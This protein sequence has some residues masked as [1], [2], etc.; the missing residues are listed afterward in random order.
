M[1]EL[2]AGHKESHWM[3]FIFPQ[4]KSLGHSEM[5]DR[6]AMSGAAEARAYLAHD[7]LGLRLDECV[8]A[9]LD[10][11]EIS[12]LQILGSPDDL[13]LRSCLTLFATVGSDGLV[14]QQALDQFT[15]GKADERTLRCF[16]SHPI[17][18][19]LG[20][21]LVTPRPKSGRGHDQDDKAQS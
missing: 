2:R 20:E 1:D 21:A 12:A 4:V 9:L 15:D 6:F 5:A 8:R 18:L 16:S 11:H 10:H 7:M 17:F 13:K 3:W 19:R 14:Y